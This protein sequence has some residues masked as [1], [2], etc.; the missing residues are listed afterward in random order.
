MIAPFVN[1]LSCLVRAWCAAECVSNPSFMLSLCPT[2]CGLCHP[3]C[4][5]TDER[6]AGFAHLG[7]CE[8]N[9]EWMARTCPVA[10]GICRERCKDAQEECPRWMAGGEC[11]INPDFMHRNCPESCSVCSKL[12]CTDHNATQC[13]MWQLNGECEHNAAF[14][15]LQHCQ[16]LCFTPHV[17]SSQLP[18]DFG[19]CNLRLCVVLANCSASCGL[20]KTLCQDHEV[21]VSLRLSNSNEFPSRPPPH[22]DGWIWSS[23]DFASRSQEACAN[24]AQAG[25]CALLFRALE[26]VPFRR[27]ARASVA[28]RPSI[29]QTSI[30]S[31]PR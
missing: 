20:C 7:E 19:P 25:E 4:K 10:C 23:C 8:K 14:S 12:A 2:S 6:C 16:T 28:V 13:R 26:R 17:P 5:D 24:W 22:H 30:D 3:V 11:S 1:I 15:A 27:T 29:G 31:R 9:A 18:F 21:R